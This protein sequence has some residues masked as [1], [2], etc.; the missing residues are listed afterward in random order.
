MK[1]IHFLIQYRLIF[2]EHCTLSSSVRE[3][4][5]YFVRAATYL[6]LHNKDI[7]N[8]AA[9]NTIQWRLK[10]LNPLNAADYV[11]EP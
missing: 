4:H 10:P 3:T 5:I 2:G 9:D 11:G 7:Q 8:Y 1:A 6:N